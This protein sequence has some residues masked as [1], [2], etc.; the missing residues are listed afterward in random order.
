[1]DGEQLSYVTVRFGENVSKRALVDTGAC[2]K[3]M[4]QSLYHQ[5]RLKISKQEIWKI[6][7]FL[8]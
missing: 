4:P 5:L 1:M 8:L 7:I 2:G 3:A 6:L